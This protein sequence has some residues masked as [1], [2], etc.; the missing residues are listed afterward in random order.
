MS[1]SVRNRKIL[2]ANSGN[3][4]AMCRIELIQKENQESSLILGEECHI[5]SSK[6]DGPR[7][8]LAL[9]CNDFD[10]C[11]N[12]ILL[13]A[14]DHKRI[15]TLIDVYPLETLVLIKAMHENWVKTTLSID[16]SAFTNIESKVVS[17][18]EINNGSKLLKLLDG[19]HGSMLEY[20][21]LKSKDEIEIIPILFDLIKDFGE[22]LEFMSYEDKEKLGLEL[23]KNIADLN[24]VNFKLFGI[25]RSVNL[26]FNNEKSKT[27]KTWDLVT[28]IAVRIDNP[29]IVDRFLITKAP[30]KYS[31]KI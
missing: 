18:E 13:C 3:R 30:D 26:K 6:K 8:N 28:I 25:R 24:G 5:I 22:I 19:A 16:P 17:L 31:F 29:G 23:S 15:D 2:W 7:G 11:E 20:E 27:N 4:C 10:D 1:I 12:L 21:D 9:H 14:N